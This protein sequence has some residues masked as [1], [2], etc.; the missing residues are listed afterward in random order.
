LKFSS[1]RVASAAGSY[2]RSNPLNVEV[3]KS[4]LEFDID[5]GRSSRVCQ[6]EDDDNY[7]GQLEVE[8]Q[9]NGNLFEPI[10]FLPIFKISI[11]S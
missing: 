7:Y 3:A 2:A 4:F 5:D 1:L 9:E 8:Y 10:I 11:N 6:N